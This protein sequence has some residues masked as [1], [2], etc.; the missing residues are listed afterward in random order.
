MT[1]FASDARLWLDLNREYP[2]SE[3]LDGWGYVIPPGR[4][5]SPPD[6]N[7]EAVTGILC[8]TCRERPAGFGSWYRRSAY[9]AHCQPLPNTAE[10]ASCGYSRAAWA[11]RLK[12]NRE[13]IIVSQAAA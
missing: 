8:F 6:L 13:E 3:P 12:A 11:A 4:P 5:E 9:C 10:P 7:L 1:N 2:Q